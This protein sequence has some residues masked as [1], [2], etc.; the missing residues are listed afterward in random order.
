MQNITK[1]YKIL[2]NIIMEISKFGS[3]FHNWGNQYLRHVFL[4]FVGFLSNI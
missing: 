2:Q 1:Y 3:S 4:I